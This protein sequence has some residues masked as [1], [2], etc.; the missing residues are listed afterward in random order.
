MKI[1]KKELVRILG[2]MKGVVQK[3]DA[4]PALSGILVDNGYFIGTNQEI[5]VKIKSEYAAGEKFVIPMEA[6]DLIN[7][8][9]DE[10]VE[11][12]SDK[13]TM[14]IKTSAIRNKFSTHDADRFSYRNTGETTSTLE[15]DGLRMSDAISNVIFAAADDHASLKGIHMAQKGNQYIVEASDGH[16]LA[17]DTVDIS[18][19]GMDVIIPKAAAKKL[20]NVGLYG[21]VK[22]SF[23]KVGIQFE[24]A[25]CM[26]GSQLFAGKYPDLDK[27]MTMEPTMKVEARRKDVQ[28]AIMRAD[29]CLTSQ[30][31]I[32]VRLDISGE[33]MKVSIVD[34]NSEFLENIPV[35]S[36][37]GEKMLI[38][39]DSKLAIN[40]LKSFDDDN[41]SIGLSGKR[42]P[43]I[44]SGESTGMKAALLPVNIA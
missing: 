20:L 30:T 34:R 27:I 6:F 2:K 33:T 9:P 39:F 12:T 21:K 41:I 10:D 18:G 23:G 1:E 19:Q 26:I 7:N 14:A 3:N 43:S 40:V 29:A 35:T 31:K 44:W 24:T 28:E 37:S 42:M 16:V 17:R 15:A 13:T 38:G 5:T 25:D 36:E 32:P 11:I 22:I 4:L 8:L